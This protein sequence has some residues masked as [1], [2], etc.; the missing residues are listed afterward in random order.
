[1]LA[2]PSYNYLSGRRYTCTLNFTLKRDKLYVENN[3]AICQCRVSAIVDILQCK[4]TRLCKMI[5][6]CACHDG[7][8]SGV[9]FFYN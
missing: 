7:F 6:V 5:H 1:M 9:V 2:K 8:E 4:G 3:G